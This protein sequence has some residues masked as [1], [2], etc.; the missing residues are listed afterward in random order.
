MFASRI[1]PAEDIGDN[2]EIVAIS[3]KD[4]VFDETLRFDLLVENCLLLELKAVEKILPIHKAQIYSY[5]KLLDIPVGLILNFHE[6]AMRNG[7]SRVT[8][9]NSNLL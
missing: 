4:L 9:P 1:S 2:Q 5:M 6:A 7:I 3:Y 8:L